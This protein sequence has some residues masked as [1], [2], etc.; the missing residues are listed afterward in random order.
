M[1]KYWFL[2][3]FRVILVVV[4]LVGIWCLK[5]V[6]YSFFLNRKLWDLRRENR[7]FSGLLSGW[8]V[9]L[10]FVNFEVWYWG[11]GFVLGFLEFF[12]ILLGWDI[13]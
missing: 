2:G 11:V 12:L 13:F 4:F 1:E 3:F 5:W 9:F 7:E 6:N 10:M 8:L